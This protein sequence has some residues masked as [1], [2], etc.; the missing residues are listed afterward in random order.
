VSFFSELKRRNVIRVSGVYAI[1]SWLLLQVAGAL[2]SGMLLPDWFDRLVL[3]VLL[4]GFP[5]AAIFAW[6]FELTPEGIKRTAE[7]DPDESITARTG[8]R[9]DMFLAL[10]LFAFAAAIVVPQFLPDDRGPDAVSPRA[11]EQDRDTATRETSDG[12]SIAVLP[13]ADLSPEGDQE[14][15]SDGISEEI[16]NVL[17]QIPELRVAARTS[18]F[19]FKEDQRSIAEVG[20]L[21]NVDH[22]LEGSVRKA[23]ARLRITAQLIEADTGY[24]LWSNS[25]DREL[26][27]VFA[28][29]DEI[30]TAI[31]E[32]LSIAMDLERG[33]NDASQ[34]SDIDPRAYD[35]YLQARELISTTNLRKRRG[36]ISLL[37]KAILVEPEF[38]LARAALVI[39]LALTTEGYGGDLEK[40]EFMDRVAPELAI[41]ERGAPALPELWRAKS[42]VAEIDS[43]WVLALAHA[44]RALTLRRNYSA[45]HFAKSTALEKLLRPRERLAAIERWLAIDP[46]SSFAR[47]VAVLPL[48]RVDP[49][50]ADALAESL[51]GEAL[52]YGRYAKMLAA[53]RTGQGADALLQGLLAFAVDPDSY[54]AKQAAWIVMAAYGF[55]DEAERLSMGGDSVEPGVA[56]AL[57][58]RF[59]EAEDTLRRALEE[60]PLDDL[61][62]TFLASSVYEQGRYE[63]ASDLYEDLLTKTEEGLAYSGGGTTPQY[64]GVLAIHAFREAGKHDTAGKL[65]ATFNRYFHELDEMGKM[66][67]SEM[68]Y[69]GMFEAIN[70]QYSA[71]LP[72]LVAAVELGSAYD[73]RFESPVFDPLRKDATFQAI[74]VQA[75]EIYERHRAEMLALMC[76]NNPIPDIWQPLEST[77]ADR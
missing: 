24:H 25:Y 76:E 60:G 52:L 33:G 32:A 12:T 73:V 71:A 58:G 38:F 11:T 62:L 8:S 61:G 45:A 69:R 37:E 75:Q 36:G 53:L 39:G 50:R 18:S 42:F 16:L 9:L 55:Q 15:F 17:A 35:W 46:L 2:E 70:E 14:Y 41:V 51:I 64:R 67:P 26:T 21:L 74:R 65:A 22:V 13:F 6:A 68:F 48:A 31:A 23:G 59:R 29:Q 1:V 19:L 28:V 4:I 10:G 49:E 3:A 20:E 56:R 5:L 63:E 77:C 47:A 54:F 34:P 57:G 72:H 30:A 27:D 66:F 7:V 44:N 40:K 43:D